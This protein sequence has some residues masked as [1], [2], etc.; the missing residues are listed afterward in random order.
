MTNIRQATD[1]TLTYVIVI[2]SLPKW[3][4]QDTCSAADGNIGQGDWCDCDLVLAQVV[5][6]MVQST[7][8]RSTAFRPLD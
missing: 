5:V 3:V 4:S 7:C 8:S 1:Q 2:W 6:P